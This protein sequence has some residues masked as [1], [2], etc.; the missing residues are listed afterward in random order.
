M[1][2]KY[3]I[4]IFL[5]LFS[6]IVEASRGRTNSSGCHTSKKE[7]YHCHGGSSYTPN[8]SASGSP[9]AMLATA[10]VGLAVVGV[11]SAVDAISNIGNDTDNQEEIYETA[12]DNEALVDPNAPIQTIIKENLTEVIIPDTSVEPV[13]ESTRTLSVKERLQ[14]LEKKKALKEKEQKEIK[15]YFGSY[16]NEETNKNDGNYK[17]TLSTLF[18]DDVYITVKSQKVE[19]IA[20]N[21]NTLNCSN[22][23]K[24]LESNLSKIL[25]EKQEKT[26][27]GKYTILK[28]KDYLTIFKCD[29]NKLSSIFKA[30]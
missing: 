16:I 4:L 29:N 7:G 25:I 2:S 28:S 11:V 13:N 20:T 18:F 23:S 8:L 6:N 27:K 3:T 21:K 26:I 1:K 14:I 22:E 19:S 9:E 12:Q 5:V 17:Q 30:N 24:D 10:V 15:N